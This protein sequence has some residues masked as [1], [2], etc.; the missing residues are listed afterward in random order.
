MNPI[1]LR[2]HIIYYSSMRTST[3]YG[4]VIFK[5]AESNAAVR[6]VSCVNEEVFCQKLTELKASTKGRNSNVTVFVNDE[7][8]DAAK[9]WLT[10]GD[11]NESLKRAD[12]DTIKRKKWVVENG[13]IITK[14]RKCVIPK[15]DLFETLTAAHS[16]I[17]HRGR[18][19]TERYIHDSFSEISQDVIQLFVSLCKLHLQQKS[20]TDHVKK[21][22]LKPLISDGFLKH[23][24]IDLID[25]RKIA[26]N[27]CTKP[28][29][30]V[31]HVIDHYS[32][33]SW[34]Y[35][36]HSKC[37][38]EVI[39]ALQQQFYLF[40]FPRVLH[41]D[42]GR[43]FKN[44]KMADFCQMNSIKQVH[45]SPRTPTTQG[46]VE[47]NNKTI[48]E[49]MSNILKEKEEDI[50]KWC[51]ILNEA[52][53]KKNICVHS[54]TKKSPYEI[55]FSMKPLKKSIKKKKNSENSHWIQLKY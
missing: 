39:E 41:S 13:K 54:A 31:L 46:L 48:K 28:H 22:V 33:Y 38:E 49:N 26:C 7:F 30:W 47:R 32:K 16:A 3:K 44:T 42:N 2:H 24:E 52:A 21:P 4:L 23:V 10:S 35:A 36:L 34:L 6:V 55:V 15:R 37:T 43:E 14:D 8:Y 27:T 40:G 51:T 12:I 11:Y 29:Q 18:D 19:K 9:A 5:M 20:I 1:I 25:F 17:A 45:G 50:Q 53:Y